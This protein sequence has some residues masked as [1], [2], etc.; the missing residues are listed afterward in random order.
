MTVYAGTFPDRI[1]IEFSLSCNL[2]CCM[3]LRRFLDSPNRFMLKSLFTKIVDEVSGYPLSAIVIFFRGESLLGP[4]FFYGGLSETKDPGQATACATKGLLMTHDMAGYLLEK[5]IDFVSFSLDAYTKETYEQIR[6]GSDFDTVI[7]NVHHFLSP[8][9]SGQYPRCEVHVSAT[10]NEFN[11][12]ELSLFSEYWKTYV[13]RV[14][15]YPQHSEDGVFEK[16]S[17]KDGVTV[18][19]IGLEGGLVRNCLM[20]W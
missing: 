13:D 6:R 20:L 11:Q 19:Q 10:K 3:S 14:R 5:G 16:L 17:K 9:N 8:N 7:D 1:T 2:R 4:G 18:I 12:N 15:V